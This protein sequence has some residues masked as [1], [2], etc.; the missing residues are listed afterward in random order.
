MKFTNIDWNESM[1][2]W[3][4]LE[5]EPLRKDYVVLQLSLPVIGLSIYL[6]MKGA[7]LIRAMSSISTAHKWIIVE[8][9][10]K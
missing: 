4:L 6:A 1:L 10:S 9:E 2:G 5:Q 7:L 8:R 3:S